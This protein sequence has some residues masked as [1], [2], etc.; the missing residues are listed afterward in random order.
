MKDHLKVLLVSQHAV[1][2]H[3]L[4]TVL[5]FKNIEMVSDVPPGEGVSA[6]AETLNPD[7]VLVDVPQPDTFGIPLAKELTAR[8]P[9]SKIVFLTASQTEAD[10]RAAVEAK[11]SGYFSKNIDTER[12]VNALYLIAEGETIF[13]QAAFTLRT[14]PALATPTTESLTNREHEILRCLALGMPNKAIARQL[15]LAEGTVKVH[16]K[17]ILRKLDLA[18][19][20][21]A[22]VYMLKQMPELMRPA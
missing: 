8:H 11:V 3:G 1:I 17:A 15:T 14:R 19:R 16:I 22:A 6:L 5:T 9:E 18:N 10:I 21:Q 12:L 4:C 13:P 7:I 20:T 2:R